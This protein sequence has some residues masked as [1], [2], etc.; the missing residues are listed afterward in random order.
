L[1]DET[2]R[3]KFEEAG[4]ELKEKLN[5]K[6]VSTSGPKNK[7]F[8][9][10]LK[11]GTSVAI[12]QKKIQELRDA[13]DIQDLK[14]LKEKRSEIIK[15]YLEK[16]AKVDEEYGGLIEDYINKQLEWRVA[17]DRKNT[18][19]TPGKKTESFRTAKNKWEKAL[20]AKILARDKLV[21]KEGEM[22]EV[23]EHA[24]QNLNSRT[25]R[26]DKR[27]DLPKGKRSEINSQLAFLEKHLRL[28]DQGAI[29]ENKNNG[30]FHAHSDLCTWYVITE[31]IVWPH[32][33]ISMIRDSILYYMA[34]EN[35]DKAEEEAIETAYR[36]MF[37]Q[38]EFDKEYT[39]IKRKIKEHKNNFKLKLK[40]L[41]S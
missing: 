6:G 35:E 4:K 11:K 34:T 10:L 12:I 14:N 15:K 16:A 29:T 30:S 33:K 32:P 40:L 5:L 22:E 8:N 21:K 1:E 28:L 18:E 37:A 13:L 19:D 25:Y 26:M 23:G 9:N 31:F 39:T 7:I 20:R 27:K 3:E 24:F 36:W 38:H 2:D 17:L 41:K